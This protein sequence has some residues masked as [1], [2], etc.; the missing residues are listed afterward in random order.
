MAKQNDQQ[1]VR[2][3]EHEG[4]TV[5]VA[6]RHARQ[7]T[8]TTD[9]TCILQNVPTSSSKIARVVLRRE[10]IACPYAVTPT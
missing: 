10:Q 2:R 9:L 5:R 1:A 3:S 4:C 8:R 6:K 7:Q